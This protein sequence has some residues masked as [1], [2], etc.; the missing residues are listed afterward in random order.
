[1]QKA[2]VIAVVGATSWDKLFTWEWGRIGSR[3][4]SKVRR[5]RL[6]GA[7][8]R[9][10]ARKTLMHRFTLPHALASPPASVCGTVVCSWWPGSRYHLGHMPPPRPY[11]GPAQ[12]EEELEKRNK[13][14]NK[15]P[16][17]PVYWPALVKSS[18]K[19]HTLL[20]TNRGHIVQSN[21]FDNMPPYS[22][23][24]FWYIPCPRGNIVSVL[25]QNERGMAEDVDF[26]IWCSTWKGAVKID[27]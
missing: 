25:Q 22:G 7:K 20:P 15:N 2:W 21:R 14:K 5:L 24:I 12:L 6:T 3:R 8:G 26:P 27:F 17:I 19:R 10:N 1:M 16:L 23:D 18:W 13:K 9:V 4:I 11:A